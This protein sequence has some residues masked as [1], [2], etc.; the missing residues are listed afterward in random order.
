[1]E[2]KLIFDIDGTILSE[3]DHTIPSSTIQAI[4]EAQKNG[5]LC[6]INTGRPLSTIDQMIKDIG[7]DGYVCGCGTYIE[8]NHDIL[9]H[10]EVQKETRKTV[11][12]KSIEYHIDTMLE[13]KNGTS[14]P[15]KIFH[16]F[17]REIKENYTNQNFN[18][19]EYS[20]H[21]SILF[22]KFASW[23]T[24]I[25]D[26]DSFKKAIS[27]DFDIIQREN[28]FI[29]VV[30]KGLSKASGIQF[31]VDYLQTSR[32]QTI[33]I[34]DSTND[35]AMLLYTKESVA[36]GNSHPALFDKVTYITDAL[37]NDGIYQALKHFHII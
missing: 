13:G 2:T 3:K 17:V 25:S 30:P 12:Q 19:G 22:D 33:S 26:I 29:E 28:D 7:F 18:I 27:H 31:L 23:Y 34:G 36:M 9:F 35:L 20:S 37:E 14:F 15:S 5:H 1:M 32:D 4:K 16:P 6:F 24:D 11:I 8:Y 10:Q 21:D